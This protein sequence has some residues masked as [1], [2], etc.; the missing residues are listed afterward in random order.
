MFNSDTLRGKYLIAARHM[1]DPNFFRAAVLMLDHNEH[2]AMGLIINRPSSVS[3]AHA[4]SKH[5]S[6][7]Q[8]ERMIYF[9]GPV[10]PAA[11]CILHNDEVCGQEDHHLMPGVF[12][13][14]HE[15]VFENVVCETGEAYEESE[16]RVYSGYAGWGTDQLEGEIER[17]DW[18]V[19]P[20]DAKFVFEVEPYDVWEELFNEIYKRNRFVNCIPE[21]VS[22]N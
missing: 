18:H 22:W 2:G 6:V 10:E 5:F 14:S 21:R 13:G 19:V 17:G 4:L 1:Q 9:G 7:P 16:Y 11:L 20:G 8:S 3:V 12:I 15:Q